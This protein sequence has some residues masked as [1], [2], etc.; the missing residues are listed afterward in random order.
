MCLY[1]CMYVYHYDAG[2]PKE[3]YTS[4]NVYIYESLF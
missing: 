3:A 4:F 1:V 2:I